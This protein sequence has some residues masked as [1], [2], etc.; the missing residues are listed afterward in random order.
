M[1]DVEGHRAYIITPTDRSGLVIITSTIFMSW[2]VSC[3]F[4]RIY[5]RMAI[6]GPFDLDDT[7]AGIGTV[8]LTNATP[9]QSNILANP[10]T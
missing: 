1:S 8:N 4:I 6:T 5:T 10:Y 7:V 2:M 3:Y 9:F